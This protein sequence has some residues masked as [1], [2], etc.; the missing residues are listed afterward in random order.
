MCRQKCE[1]CFSGYKMNKISE[2][3]GAG[4]Y[5]ISEFHM[6]WN[7]FFWRREIIQVQK[8]FF[9]AA[10]LFYFVYM[11][12]NFLFI[13]ANKYAHFTIPCENLPSIHQEC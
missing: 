2:I 10:L 3:L 9:T 5:G 12:L 4:I 11:A 6:W 8:F 13:L 7:G 1:M